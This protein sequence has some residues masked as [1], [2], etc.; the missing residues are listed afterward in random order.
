MRDPMTMAP[1]PPDGNPVKTSAVR[2][3]IRKSWRWILGALGLGLAW[4]ALAAVAW[5]EV[6]EL[7]AGIGPSAILLLLVINLLMLPLMTA[8]WWLILKILGSPVDLLTACAY[9]TAANAVSYLSPG[10][11]FGGEPL[12]V[13]L[14]HH[15]HGIPLSSAATSVALDRMLELLA[16]MVVLTF[17]LICLGLVEN[18]PFA[19]SRGLI[20]VIA[21]L[22][23]FTCILALLFTGKKPFS[24]SAFPLRRFDGLMDVIARGEAM[25]EAVFRGHRGRFLVANLLSLAHWTGVFAEFWLMSFVLGFPLSLWNLA[26]VV[27]V[28]RLAFFTPLPAGIG[29]LESALPWLTDTLGLGSAF[30]LSLCLVIRIRDLLFSLAGL[31]LTMQYLTCRRKAVIIQK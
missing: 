8:R 13:Y 20:V 30:G 24:R 11:H 19:E 25:A 12:S 2:Q 28:A 29:V 9:R 7:L 31:G 18:G 10:P 15:R 4:H 14:L 3:G 17:C 16:S 23:A 26:A 5:S 22:L 27:A 6:W 21:V 1:I